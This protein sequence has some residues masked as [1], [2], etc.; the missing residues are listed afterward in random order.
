MGPRLLWLC[1]LCRRP[2]PRQALLN[3]LGPLY[4]VLRSLLEEVF[5]DRPSETILF[6]VWCKEQKRVNEAAGGDASFEMA[7]GEVSDYPLLEKCQSIIWGG[8]YV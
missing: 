1:V 6:S 4:Q 8:G 3:S 5:L 7:A 2:T